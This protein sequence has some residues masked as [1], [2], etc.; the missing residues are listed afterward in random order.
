MPIDHYHLRRYPSDADDIA[1][2]LC[3][4]NG[5]ATH[6]VT[7]DR[8]FSEVAADSEFTICEPLAFLAELRR[9]PKT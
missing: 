9:Q 6:L 8:G 3:A 1:F 7:Y 2:V 4:V 5:E